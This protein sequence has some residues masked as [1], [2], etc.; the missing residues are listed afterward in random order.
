L[1]DDFFKGMT[2]AERHFGAY[3][4]GSIRP[5]QD[6]LPNQMASAVPCEAVD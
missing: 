3:L 6:E 2:R 5:P 4:D 1:N